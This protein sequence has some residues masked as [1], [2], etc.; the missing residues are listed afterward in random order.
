MPSCSLP[1]Q[2]RPP[3]QTILLLQNQGFAISKSLF[4]S[5]AWL[6]GEESAQGRVKLSPSQMAQSG[7]RAPEPC[8]VLGHPAPSPAAFSAAL[9]SSLHPSHLATSQLGSE[10]LQQG[11][12]ACLHPSATVPG[13]EGLV[14]RLPQPFT[15]IPYHY[16]HFIS[17]KAFKLQ[18]SEG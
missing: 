4:K 17:E 16:F 1:R 2:E 15:N 11:R 5:A 13:M 18:I 3:K 9:C 7:K 12:S 14:L 8:R 10:E 6:H